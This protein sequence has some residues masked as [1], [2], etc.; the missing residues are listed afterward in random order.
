MNARA[1]TITRGL[2][3]SL[4]GG[5]TELCEHPWLGA[6][7]P[8]ALPRDAKQTAELLRLCARE[9]WRVLP[10]G[11]GSKLGWSAPPAR[12]DLALSTRAL[13]GVVAYEPG[14]GTL[15]ARAGTT[16]AEIEQLVFAGGHRLTPDVPRPAQATLGGMIAAGQSGVCRLRLGPARNH[17]LGLVAALSDGSSSKSGGRLVK[18]VTGF[19]L[20]R[21]HGGAH[22]SLGVILEASLRLFPLPAQE[23]AWS[24]RV[25]RLAQAF[26]AAERLLVADV[27]PLAVVIE[28]GL[29]PSEPAPRLH[30]L[31]AGRA[32]GVASELARARTILGAR[33]LEPSAGEAARALRR[34]LRDLEPDARQTLSL[35]ISTRPSRLER[36]LERTLEWLRE[37]DLPRLVLAHPGL[38][39]LD[40]PLGAAQGFDAAAATEL[41]A[42]VE[43]LREALEPA[44]RVE[45]R[46]GRLALQSPELPAP[47]LELERRLRAALDPGGVLASDRC[48]AAL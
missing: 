30:A 29:D 26:E 33:E 17:V 21:L 12:I 16:L 9:G 6:P 19:D 20:H 44:A 45:L 11:A 32:E 13:A 8:M 25:P 22:G 23:A 36:T 31:F 1:E 46:G 42:A 28:E 18:N 10:I 7:L 34:R 40:L 4:G 2:E 5:H 15:T 37:H 47:V 24:L 43:H 39:T 35:H 41:R 14:D 38:A 3:R 27:E 48:R